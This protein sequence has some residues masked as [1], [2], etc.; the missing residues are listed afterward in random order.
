MYYY[1]AL[2]RAYETIVSEHRVV[3]VSW[4]VPAKPAYYHRLDVAIAV[5]RGLPAEWIDRR[6]VEEVL[7]VSKTVA[8]RIMR[9]CGAS[10]GP[11]NTL[12]CRREELILALVRLQSTGEFDREIRRRE[13]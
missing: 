12:V 9:R 1:R 11:G 3:G 8:W 10:D 2:R 5:F 7:R 13:R 6:T 4:I